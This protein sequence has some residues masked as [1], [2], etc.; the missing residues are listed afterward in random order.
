[1][2]TILAIA[3]ITYALCTVAI[4][5]IIHDM[6]QSQREIYREQQNMYKQVMDRMMAKNLTDYKVSIGEIEMPKPKV[7]T[8][9]E[10]TRRRLEKLTQEKLR[11]AGDL[12]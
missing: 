12:E 7:T 4:T 5:Y 8:K 1:M 11:K 6:L 3:I 10:N 9:A 2:D